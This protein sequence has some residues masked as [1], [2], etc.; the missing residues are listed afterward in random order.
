[1]DRSATISIKS[2]AITHGS[3]HPPVNKREPTLRKS[4]NAHALTRWVGA[5]A[6]A[7]DLEPEIVEQDLKGGGLLLLCSDGLWNYAQ[8]SQEMAALVREFQHSRARPRLRFH[9]H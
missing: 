6:E 2:L 7:D 5:D 1:M 8:D 4:A 3:T 9:A